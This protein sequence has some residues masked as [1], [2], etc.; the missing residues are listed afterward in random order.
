MEKVRCSINLRPWSIWQ[1]CHL[2]GFRH[3][4][5]RCCPKSMATQTRQ[6]EVH[7]SATIPH[8]PWNNDDPRDWHSHVRGGGSRFGYQ[9]S[10]SPQ[11]GFKEGDRPGAT[12][13]N[14]TI[15]PTATCSHC[16]STR[17]RPLQWG[18]RL[19]GFVGS[20]AGAAG[21]AVAG[22]LG[23]PRL[24]TQPLQWVSLVSSAVIGGIAAGAAGCRS[25]ASLGDLL[26]DR[27]L[28]NHRC[29]DCAKRFNHPMP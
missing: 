10:A 16:A 19:G 29:L 20:V 24:S 15:S 9:D 6:V 3:S 21:G 22:C 28:P 23:A 5:L 25:G 11:H 12:D 7:L 1:L 18:R 26:D 17:T 2:L 8:D 4:V 14:T 27:I 13:H